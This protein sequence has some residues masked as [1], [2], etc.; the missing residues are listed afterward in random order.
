MTMIVGLAL[1][2]ILLAM[3]GFSLLRHGRS[4]G[5]ARRHIPFVAALVVIVLFFLLWLAIMV[6]SVGPSLKSSS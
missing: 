5:A 6:F 1:A 2:A 3:S 4:P